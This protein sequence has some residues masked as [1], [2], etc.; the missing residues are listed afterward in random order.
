MRA[1]LTILLIP[2]LV[3]AAS[4]AQ[5]N[6]G[7]AMGGFSSAPAPSP[8]NRAASEF[9]SGLRELKKGD[10]L[11]AEAAKLAD[12]GKQQKAQQRARDAYT[13]ARK[14]FQEA[15]EYNAQLPEAWNDLGYTQRKLGDYTAAL[16]AYEKALSLRPDYPEA[17]EYRGEAY[18]G[19]GRVE[20]AKNTYLDLFASNRALSSQLLEAIKSWVEVKRHDGSSDSAMIDALD[21]WVQERSQI[22][23]QTAALTREG[24]AASWK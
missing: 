9:N 10:S 4:A 12:P 14:E 6:S 11:Q 5:A 15:I 8:E 19:A 17:L 7:G 1:K 3:L 20:D 21:K 24:T 13:R 22:A 18:L 23:S 2:S 16:T